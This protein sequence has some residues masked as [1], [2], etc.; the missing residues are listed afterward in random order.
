MSLG[1][2][3]A[4]ACLAVFPA[5][6]FA[7]IVLTTPDWQVEIDPATLAIV[8]TPTGRAPV[9]VSSGNTARQVG[10]LETGGNRASWQWENGAIR[11]AARLEGTDLLLTVHAERD[12]EIALINQPGKAMG[13]G[14]ML[15]LAEG[16]YF[17]AGDPL[18]QRFLP[19]HAKAGMNTSQDLGLPMWGLDHGSFTLSWLILNPFGNTLSFTGSVD[20]L[21][22]TLTHRTTPLDRQEPALLMLHLGKGNDLLAGARRYRRWLKDEHRF[23]ALAD[24][25]RAR[26]AIAKL[27]GAS[28]AY[29]WGNG[30]LGEGDIRDW[31][32]W[33]ATLKSETPL[34]RDLRR[35]FEPEERRLL[36]RVTALP[37][38]YQKRVLLAAFNQA[39]AQLARDATLTGSPDWDNLGPVYAKLRDAV[40]DTF[41]GSLGPDRTRF[42]G[43]LSVRNVNALEEAGL[44]RLWL[45]AESW[46]GGLWHPEA[47]AAGIRAG[48][49]M[50]TY[51]SYETALKPGI[52]QDWLSAQLGERAYRDCG[53][54][55]AA[56]KSVAG[57][58][59]EGRY[60]SAACVRPILQKRVTALREAAGFNSWF[61]DA[62]ATGM[63]FDDYRPGKQRGQAGQAVDNEASMAWVGERFGMPVGSENGNAA[64][65]LGIDFAHGMQVP[66]LGWGDADMQKN[67]ASPYF[68]GRWYPDGEPEVFFKPVPL[69]EPFRT[70]YFA[71]EYRLPLY[72]AVFHDSIITTNHWLYDNLKFTNVRD[73]NLLAQMLYNVPPLVHLS[74]GTLPARIRVL[75]C[76]DRFFRPLHERLATVA[77]T[78][79]DWLSDDRKVQR[80]RFADGTELIANFSNEPRVAADRALAPL[81][82]LA[83]EPGKPPG[84]FSA[85]HCR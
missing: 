13:R 52:R 38:R 71:P 69:K 61:L 77:L 9:P 55:D 28:H 78:G 59:G 26:P 11:L 39:A 66:V 67:R 36:G 37:D 60:T 31:P 81:S 70:V 56:G 16:S 10:K 54:I 27:V 25:I 45:G 83:Q 30:L 75:T 19:A 6:A 44:R 72:Q 49:L 4:P 3:L 2:R 68:L 8:A 14:L 33:L 22:M 51:D 15:P 50:S 32:A 12:G 21:A 84:I 63:V 17:P 76:V 40:Y 42:G 79:F 62:Y 65:S 53:I 43:T 35:H 82:L 58:M 47:V 34:A 64:T 46:E 29:L 7:G 85:K 57:F 1:R 24:K 18:G 23:V 80:T 20:G 73:D 48:F 74:T 5:W 41:S